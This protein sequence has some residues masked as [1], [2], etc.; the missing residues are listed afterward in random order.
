[1]LMNKLQEIG[2]SGI[3]PF[4]YVGKED[5]HKYMQYEVS[6][7]VYVGRAANQ[8]KV[9]KLLYLKNCKSE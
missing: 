2:H 1:M 3:V 7:T 5:I 4:A 6:M 9:P 8:R